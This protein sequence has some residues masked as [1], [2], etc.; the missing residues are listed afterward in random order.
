MVW[1]KRNTRYT[2]WW[3]TTN[4]SK[5]IYGFEYLVNNLSGVSLSVVKKLREGERSEIIVYLG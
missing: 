2:I 5:Y 4:K 3:K 1:F